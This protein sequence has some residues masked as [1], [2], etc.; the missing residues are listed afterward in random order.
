MFHDIRSFGALL[1][2]KKDI[3]PQALFGHTSAHVTAP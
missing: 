3:D 2:G 1:Y